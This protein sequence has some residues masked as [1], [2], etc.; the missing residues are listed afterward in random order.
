MKK[1]C[2]PIFRVT[3][4]CTQGIGCKPEEYLSTTRRF[5]KIF[6]KYIGFSAQSFLSLLPLKF[7]PLLVWSRSSRLLKTCLVPSN[8]IRSLAIDWSSSAGQLLAKKRQGYAALPLVSIS[9]KLRDRYVMLIWF[10][11]IR[12]FRPC[13]VP[14]HDRC[15]FQRWF[16][17]AGAQAW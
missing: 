7:L 15:G 12:L 3:Y 11:R 17:A 13:R 5:C 1:N 9:A 2:L 14:K 8:G 6:S 10:E 4:Q 16:E